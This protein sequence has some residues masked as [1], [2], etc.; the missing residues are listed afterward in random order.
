MW[1]PFR[2]MERD[3]GQL[4]PPCLDQQRTTLVLHSGPMSSPTPEEAGCL[5]TFS[6]TRT[7]RSLVGVSPI[8]AGHNRFKPPSII[9]SWNLL[10]SYQLL[11]MKPLTTAAR[12]AQT[13]HRSEPT[14]AEPRFLNY[15][16]GFPAHS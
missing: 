14:Q 9:N 15:E 6:S 2:A 4:H 5:G 16:A 11:W 8:M 13:L 12:D 1:E 3:E 7:F 10:L